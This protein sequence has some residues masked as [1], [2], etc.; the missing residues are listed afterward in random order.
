MLRMLSLVLIACAAQLFL[1]VV[2]IHLTQWIV[3]RGARAGLFKQIHPAGPRPEI[4]RYE[5]RYFILN[6]IFS[7]AL[8]ALTVWLYV[9]GFI[10]IDLGPPRPGVIALQCVLFVLGLDAYTYAVH[11]LMHTRWLFRRV[12]SVHH[13]SKVT[14]ALSAYS[15]HPVE[16]GAMGLYFPLALW[17]G[18]LHA[19]SLA[20]VG[21]GQ[22]FLNTVPHAGFEY[23]PR[24]WYRNALSRCFLTPYFHDVHHQTAQ[25][26]FG[27]FTTLWDRL[28]GTMPADFAQQFA[29]LHARPDVPRSTPPPS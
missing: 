10:R 23:A 14:S 21:V 3:R 12:H 26:N 19:V 7:C 4:Q 6:Q 15:F 11:R 27:G 13:R 25:H 28:F 8:S 1:S 29:R 22:F 24:G 2:S 5:R 17:L 20:I 9:A 18:D 16:W